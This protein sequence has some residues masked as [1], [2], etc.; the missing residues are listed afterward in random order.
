[1]ED[2]D[3]KKTYKFLYAP[4]KKFETVTVPELSFLMVDG[5]GNPNTALAYTQ[6]VEAL[7]SVA[8]TLK[9]TLKKEV[10]KNYAVMPLEGLWWV[11]DMREFSIENKDAWYWTMM[12]MQPPEVTVEGFQRACTEAGKKKDLPALPKMRFEPYHEGVSAQILYFGAYADEGP[13]IA[14]LHEFIH[15]QGGTLT[16]KHHEIYLGD[17]RK[18]VPEKLKTV[19]RQ[20]YKLD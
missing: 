3:L 5:Q 17:P 9:F 13:T 15:A 12:I 11:P 20:P 7:Y 4:S 1:M 14:R 18:T 10:E 6:A 16:G 2:L 19:I 8:Y